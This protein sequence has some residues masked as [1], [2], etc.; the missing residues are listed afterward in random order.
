M[1]YEVMH[2]FITSSHFKKLSN[3]DTKPSFLSYFGWCCNWGLLA[4]ELIEI[5]QDFCL[6]DLLKFI[7]SF[8]PYRPKDFL[9]QEAMLYGFSHK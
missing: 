2:L 3:L 1:F 6:N 9:D 4:A 5:F 7:F 8:L